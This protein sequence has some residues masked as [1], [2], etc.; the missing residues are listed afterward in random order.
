MWFVH[1]MCPKNFVS[2]KN[3]FHSHFQFIESEQKF[4]KKSS[5]FF[6]TLMKNLP[7]FGKKRD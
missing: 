1:P 3:F 2:L 5:V 7:N 6:A 4:L